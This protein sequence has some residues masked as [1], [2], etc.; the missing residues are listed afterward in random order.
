MEP[1]SHLLRW[2]HPAQALLLAAVALSLGILWGRSHPSSRPARR[3]SPAMIQKLREVARLETLEASL[4]K[5]IV[6]EPGPVPAGSLWGDVINWARHSLRAPR[7]RAIVFA[8][9]HYSFDLD[10]IDESSLEVSPD[11]AVAVRLPRLRVRIELRPAET[12]V[13]GSNL[14]AEET[15]QLFELARTAFEREALADPT[16]R[17]RAIR[18]AE[19]SIQA[20]F[21]GLGFREVKL[22]TPGSQPPPR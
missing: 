14:D 20:L 11:Q 9:A 15:A 10:A 12:E 2:A 19:R 22:I 13:I 5:K 6:F 3:S 16:L 21:L 4:Y 18:S 1:R 8:D 7:G 17:D